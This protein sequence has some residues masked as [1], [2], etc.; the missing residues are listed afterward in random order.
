MNKENQLVSVSLH[1][2]TLSLFCKNR[3]RFK[4]IHS[5]GGTHNQSLSAPSTLDFTC[6]PGG[7]TVSINLCG[8]TTPATLL[9][10]E[11]K[12]RAPT[13]AEKWVSCWCRINCLSLW[14]LT[15]WLERQLSQPS[16]WTACTHL[17]TLHVWRVTLPPQSSLCELLWKSSKGSLHP[18]SS[19]PPG[20]LELCCRW[21]TLIFNVVSM[22]QTLTLWTC[23]HVTFQVCNTTYFLISEM[24]II[25]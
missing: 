23:K 2:L 3:P 15:G 22:Y 18:L 11:L 1:L 14:S 24:I 17:F 4:V 6:P 10:G 13:I 19:P 25:W 21:A 16:T 12:K 8:S 5:A 20:F 9:T 7:A